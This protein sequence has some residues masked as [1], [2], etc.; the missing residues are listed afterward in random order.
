M[1]KFELTPLIS[2]TPSCTTTEGSP[3][4]PKTTTE[5]QKMDNRPKPI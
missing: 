2:L 4:C 3:S 1:L 5:K